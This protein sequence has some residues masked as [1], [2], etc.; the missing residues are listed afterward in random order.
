MILDE[1]VHITDETYRA[2]I[3]T[4]LQVLPISLPV[5]QVFLLFYAPCQRFGQTLSIPWFHLAFSTSAVFPVFSC[6]FIDRHLTFFRQF[7]VRSAALLHITLHHFCMAEEL[8]V[9][10]GRIRIEL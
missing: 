9:G 5:Q 1:L 6:R 2:V 8:R 7:R 4:I 3:A 10:F